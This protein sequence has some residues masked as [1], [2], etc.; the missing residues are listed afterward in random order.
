MLFLTLFLSLITLVSAGDRTKPTP[1]TCGTCW[2]FDSNAADN[3]KIDQCS[4]VTDNI[5]TAY[6]D[7]GCLCYFYS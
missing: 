6:L 3:L 1:S 7:K 4:Q 2:L 5:S